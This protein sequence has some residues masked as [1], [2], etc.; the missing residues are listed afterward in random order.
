M[1]FSSSDLAQASFITQ[2]AGGAI[3][4]IGSYF[5]AA[6][7]KSSLRFQADMADINSRIDELGA[8][9][10][11]LKG[12]RATAELTRK[13]GALKGN[14][15]ASMAA[16]G[17]DLGV[18]SAAEV[19]AST[20]LMK[21]IDKNTIAANAVRSAWGY[22]M[23]ATSETAKGLIDNASSDSIS[24]LGSAGA[25]LLS[26]AGTVAQSWYNYKTRDDLSSLLASALGK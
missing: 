16:N 23:A 19:T 12:E 21:E 2:I 6:S 25:S 14:Q 26:S 15:R 8:Q 13:A 11:L 9:G 24:P 5:S 4:G 18:G 3:S 20:D 17:I 7:K 22:R 1:Q 10:E